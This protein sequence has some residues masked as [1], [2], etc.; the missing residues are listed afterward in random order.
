MSALTISV[1]KQRTLCEEIQAKGVGLHT[2]KQVALTLRPAPIDAGI[3]FRRV[4]LDPVVEIPACFEQVSGTLLGTTLQVDDASI[5]TVE[6]LLSAFSGLGVDNAYVDLDGIEVPIMDG[7]A[8]P[9][10]FLIQ[11]AGICE[12]NAPKKFLRILKRIEVCDQDKWAAIEPFNGTRLTVEIIYD[13]PHTGFSVSNRKLDFQF[14]STAFAKEISRARTFGFLSD[15]EALKERNLALGGSLDNAVVLDEREILNQECLRFSNE[16]VRHKLL[17]ALGDLYLHKY[18]FI[19]AFFGYK[20][21][22]HLNNKLSI[23]LMNDPSSWE[24]VTFPQ[25]ELPITF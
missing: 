7:S 13:H 11:S 1:V 24:I 22:H 5:T 9:F 18:H 23:K 21:G 15:V 3:V 25:N 19:G 10:V 20:S 2:G 14:S 4:D 17:D 6:H 16:F 12:Q 8:M